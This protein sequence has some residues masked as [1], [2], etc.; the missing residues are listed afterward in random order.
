M[1][2]RSSFSQQN[3]EDII[4]D[5]ASEMTVRAM[6]MPPGVERERLLRMV[7]HDGQ[8]NLVA[9]AQPSGPQGPV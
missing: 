9:T 4:A 2:E 7:G 6:K 5:R 1:M 8:A 3:S